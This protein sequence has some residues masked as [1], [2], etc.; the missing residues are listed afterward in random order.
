MGDGRA[1]LTV[2]DLKQVLD[3][4]AASGV[5]IAALIGAGAFIL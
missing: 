5:V 2:T 1:E 4:Y 3:L